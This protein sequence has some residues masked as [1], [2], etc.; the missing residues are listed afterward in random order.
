MSSIKTTS[1]T[2][3]LPPHAT[4]I[5]YTPKTTGQKGQQPHTT[6]IAHFASTPNSHPTGSLVAISESYIC[7]AVKGGLVRVIDRNNALRCLL[8]GHTKRLTD[9]SFFPSSN[10]TN[11]TDKT[12]AVLG[13]V[14]GEGDAA[15]VLIWRIFP[16][17]Q[18]NEISTQKLLEIRYK[19]SARLIW[20]PFDPNSFL[21]VN[22]HCGPKGVA[23]VILNSM[24]LQTKKHE[25][26]DHPV[27]IC[28]DDDGSSFGDKNQVKVLSD[29]SLISDTNDVSQGGSMDAVWSIW[30]KNHVFITV[31]GKG[32]SLWSIPDKLCVWSSMSDKNFTE[33]TTID[34][35][36]IVAGAVDVEGSQSVGCDRVTEPFITGAKGNTEISLWSGFKRN[37]SNDILVEK[38][39][40]FK[41]GNPASSIQYRMA[42]CN[43]FDKN[44][45]DIP[46]NYVIL[47]DK[48]SGNLYAVHI[49]LKE[50]QNE[51]MVTGFDSVTPFEV[52][53]PI[54][55]WYVNGEMVIDDQEEVDDDEENGSGEKFEVSLF[56]VQT[57]AVQLLKLKPK[58]MRRPKLENDTD[59]SP[60]VTVEYSNDDTE[61]NDAFN[62]SNYEYE[63]DEESFDD[64]ESN[65]D[66]DEEEDGIKVSLPAAPLPP[67]G[68]MPLPDAQFNTPPDANPVSSFA[69]WL[70]SIVPAKNS[71]SL[72]D[73]IV[74]S[75]SRPT[76]AAPPGLESIISRQ[77]N[78][79]KTA[80]PPSFTPFSSQ[81]TA[82]AELI[83]KPVAPVQQEF[84]SP[85]QLLSNSSRQSSVVSR[86]STDADK[87]E[88]KFNSKPQKLPSQIIQQEKTPQTKIEPQPQVVASLPP[89]PTKKTSR[90]SG[91]SKSPKRKTNSN[92]SKS[93]KQQQPQLNAQKITLLKR[94]QNS[95]PSENVKS[96]PV[97][98]ATPSF[99]SAEMEDVIKRT[100]EAQFKLNETFMSSEFQ[101]C[102]KTETKTNLVPSLTKSLS[103]GMEQNITKSLQS[104]ISKNMKEREKKLIQDVSNSVGAS[105][106][107]P[108]VTAFREVSSLHFFLLLHIFDVIV[109]NLHRSTNI[110]KLKEYA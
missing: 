35:I 48:K 77:D 82:A 72:P 32:F 23:G 2:I 98:S 84:L 34:N 13:T 56:C 41:F 54:L 24:Y 57:K 79:P 87:E 80:N 93:K 78:Q 51:R 46:R 4:S 81:I 5:T 61:K 43:Y 45:S 59:V 21:L 8:R 92:D 44:S 76:P 101:R 95:N 68:L 86:T 19:L 94:E 103:Q 7:Y 107:E 91:L 27:C 25:T 65:E 74:S 26:E 83:Q 16:S 39:R 97:P 85:M 89:A 1:L 64:D 28:D 50:V 18:Q 38:L 52:M 75:S 47:A 71:E 69:N 73:P 110:W 62:A 14:G 67:P 106:R 49:A 96:A 29:A 42:V 6:P 105:V 104:T 12:T 37:S 11:S 108:L 63:E 33:E 30:S 102:L 31:A 100:L 58:M 40:V 3:P 22:R 90:Q 66:D 20:N 88:D 60:D 10:P 17:E 55:S 9:L 53:H 70:G 36:M 15:S 99:S 109:P